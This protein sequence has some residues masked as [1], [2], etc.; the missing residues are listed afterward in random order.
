MKDKPDSA[1][2]A[3]L[4]LGLQYFLYFGVLG[5]YLPYFNLYCF[6]LDFSG[7]QIGAMSAVRTVSTVLFPLFW[8][9]VADRFQIRKP[10]YIFCNF[11]SCFIWAAFLFTID[12]G[13][14]LG[15]S[16]FYGIFYAPVIS[17]LEAFTMDALGKK[18]NQYGRIRVWGSI[19][20]IVFVVLIGR[21]IDLQ[22]VN[23]IIPYIFAGSLLQALFSLKIPGKEIVKKGS[24]GPGARVLLEPRLIIFLAAA[25]LMLLSHGTYYGFFSIH[26]EKLG[27]GKTF[28]GITWALAS[29]AEILVM[30]NSD[31]IF[32]KISIK[33]VLIISFFIA[34]ARWL[35]LSFTSSAA[36]ILLSQVMH[37]GTYATF[38][39]ASI[40][41]IDNLIPSE[42]KTFGQAVNNA[43]TYGL[44]MTAGFIL[45]GLFFDQMDS[46]LLF[47]GSAVIAIA[48]GILMSIRIKP[49][50]EVRY[51]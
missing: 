17:F 46:S 45:N 34:A 16:I 14:M 29:V 1:Y 12:F 26:L 11:I 39:I 2:P 7:F 4:I 25:F 9:A 21:L 48:G 31:R 19:N 27:Y 13:I 8:G 3:K 44:G 38:H 24:F 43:V 22:S 23:I 18:K 6:H 40:L 47:A 49:A 37:A 35:I 50:K 36:I 20:F 42:A 51:L 30:I 10:I 41:Y 33:T 15:I 32:K 5:I 28:I